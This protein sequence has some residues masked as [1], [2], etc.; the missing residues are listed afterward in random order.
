MGK[1]SFMEKVVFFFFSPL[2][3]KSTSFF[4]CRHLTSIFIKKKKN[5]KKRIFTADELS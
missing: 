5:D 1:F 2:R 4:I 3:V